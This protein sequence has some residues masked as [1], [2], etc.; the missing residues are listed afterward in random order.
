MASL[1]K[2]PKFSGKFEEEKMSTELEEMKRLTKLKSQWVI[3]EHWQ[4]LTGSVGKQQSQKEYLR[5]LHE[6]AEF[7]N[8][9]TFCQLWNKIPHAQPCNF[10]T[11]FEDKKRTLY[12]YKYAKFLNE[13]LHDQFTL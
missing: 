13:K 12:Q 9:I 7:D 8:L 3:W 5:N 6:I 2:N 4:S 11:F 1:D 10:F